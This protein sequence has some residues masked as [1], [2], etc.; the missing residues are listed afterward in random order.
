MRLP[1]IYPKCVRVG[2]HSHCYGAHRGHGRHQLG[3]AAAR[4]GHHAA[5][6]GANV[7]AVKLARGLLHACHGRTIHYIIIYYNIATY[8][9]LVGVCTLCVNSTVINDVLKSSIRI[10]TIASTVAVR[11]WKWQ[12]EYAI[13]CQLGNGSIDKLGRL[14]YQVLTTLPEQSMTFCSLSG[15]IFSF[16]SALIPS[17]VPTA[18]KA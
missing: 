14:N 4:D 12:E 10:S 18:A 11:N 6:C 7:L 3:L 1:Q 8:S 5:G 15:T 13:M 9:L 2:V 16:A 17:K